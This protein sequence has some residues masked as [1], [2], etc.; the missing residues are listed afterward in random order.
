MMEE[1]KS[2]NEN[3]GKILKEGV[4]Q[5]AGRKLALWNSRRSFE[6]RGNL[7]RVQQKRFHC[8]PTNGENVRS[9][10]N[11]NVERSA[12]LFPVSQEIREQ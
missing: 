10:T 8:L 11:A 3:R 7:R 9:Q 6:H 5:C 2:G 4:E 1:Q 12:C